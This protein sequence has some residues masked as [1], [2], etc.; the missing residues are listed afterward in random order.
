[1]EWLEK[2]N[3]SNENKKVVLDEVNKLKEAH[4]QEVSTLDKDYQSDLADKDKV[5]KNLNNV[6]KG[7]IN[8]YSKNAVSQSEY[9]ELLD[10][11]ATY[12]NKDF[13]A[14]NKDKILELGLKSE[15]FDNAMKQISNELDY[16]NLETKKEK[17]K[18]LLEQTKKFLDE[19]K[20]FVNS[21]GDNPPIPKQNPNPPEG[22]DTTLTLREEVRQQQEK[23][24]QAKTQLNELHNIDED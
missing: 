18:H 22:N 4:K 15:L 11:L 24:N 17:S 14:E 10:K 12:E 19:N 21:N 23:Q 8:R 9:N 5:I 7:I 20:G 1:M 16:S 6:K 2:L 13:I 3:L